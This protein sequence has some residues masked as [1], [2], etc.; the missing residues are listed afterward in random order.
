MSIKRFISNL[1]STQR[2]WVVI[3]LSIVAAMLWFAL[4]S[5]ASST[6]N[7][8]SEIEDYEAEILDCAGEKSKLPACIEREES[9]MQLRI[10]KDLKDQLLSFNIEQWSQLEFQLILDLE[11]E[12]SELFKEEF[13]SQSRKVYGEASLASEQLLEETKKV[14]EDL[15]SRG[16]KQLRGNLWEEAEDSFRRAIIIES[17]NSKAL[18]GLSRALVLEEV[19]ELSKEIRILIKANL[20]DEANSVLDKAINL[21]REN[22]EV[23]D[24][25]IKIDKLIKVR[26]LLNAIRTGYDSLEKKNFLQATTFFNIALGLDKNSA[27]ALSGLR[28]VKE[29][30]KNKKIIEE[31]ILAEN[32]FSQEDFQESSFHF[33]NILDLDKNIG[34]AVVGLEKTNDYIVLEKKIDRYLDNPERLSSASVFKEARG[35]AR[36]AE[37]YTLGQRL[38]IKKKQFFMLLDQYSQP[39]TLTISSDDKTYISMR[40][41]KD[42]GFLSTKEVR[43]FPGTYTFV[44]KRKGYVTVQKTIKLINPSN[45]ILVCDK[46]I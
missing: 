20:L 46:K 35:I 8:L 36:I 14:L 19:L 15:I 7:L 44:G 32:S 27:E 11:A 6:G 43:L 3:I 34:F 30:K 26:D 41:G 33:R 40:N 24:T 28:A 39:M 10:L 16:Y 31:R 37:T 9:L 29:G 45:V 21:D 25:K 22:I 13:F 23:L 42:L 1:S 2:V 4:I 18:K 5:K 38:L 12:G 17:V